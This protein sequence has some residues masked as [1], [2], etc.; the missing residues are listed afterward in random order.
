MKVKTKTIDVSRQIPGPVAQQPIIH[1]ARK[2]SVELSTYRV[3]LFAACALFM[4]AFAGVDIA[5]IASYAVPI[6]LIHVVSYAIYKREGLKVGILS[7][8]LM[9]ALAGYGFF[10][11]QE[12][13]LALGA[14]LQ[15]VSVA[16]LIIT[17]VLFVESLFRKK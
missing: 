3:F 7:A 2:T 4:L 16:G 9:I 15:R 5:H 13:M 11:A 8:L 6:G 10:R 14:S 1:V 12:L 17:G